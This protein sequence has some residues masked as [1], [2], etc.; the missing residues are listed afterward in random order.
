MDGSRYWL[1]A[2]NKD[3]KIDSDKDGNKQLHA[4]SG[5]LQNTTRK[6]SFVTE[7][8]MSAPGSAGDYDAITI[9]MSRAL[10]KLSKEIAAELKI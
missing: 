10:V 5:I 7:S 9:N 4:S 8:K 6:I 3:K 1:S 2:S